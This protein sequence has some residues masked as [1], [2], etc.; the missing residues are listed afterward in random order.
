M[1]LNSAGLFW[2][3]L[4][5]FVLLNVLD[6]HSTYIVM[7][8]N[9]FY[10]EKNPIARFVFRKLGCFRGVVIFKA[11]LLAILIPAMSFYAGNDL[12]TINI[13]LLVANI[14]FTL[15]VFNNYRIYHKYVK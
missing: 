2:A 15:V 8:P 12:F 11:V 6:G 5:L 4:M 7:R 3:K 13:V 14:V 9:H 1:I 10:R